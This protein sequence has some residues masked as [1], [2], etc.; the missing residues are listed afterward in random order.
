MNIFREIEELFFRF[1]QDVFITA[2]KESA[3]VLVLFL[4]VHGVGNGEATHE[5]RDISFSI[6]LVNKKV[7]V[8]RH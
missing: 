8:V 4:K 7:E 1:N 5:I 6:V 3:G 2:L